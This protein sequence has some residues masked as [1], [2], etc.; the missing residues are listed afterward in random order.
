M[1]FDVRAFGETGRTRMKETSMDYEVPID[2]LRNACDPQEFGFAATDSVEPLV[3]IVGQERALRALRFGLSMENEGF[4]IYVA[5]WPGSGRTSA[6]MSFLGEVAKRKPTPPDWCYVNNFADPYYP[7]AI[8]LSPGQGRQF[9]HDVHT[10]ISEIRDRIP[11]AFESEQYT[12]KREAVLGALEQQRQAILAAAERVA[13]QKGFTIQTSPSGLALVPLKDGR[14]VTEEEF[15]ALGEEKRKEIASQRTLA[16]SEVGVAMKQARLPEKRAEERLQEM[17]RE[18]AL[19]AIRPLV[20]ELKDKYQ[21]SADVVSYLAAVQDSVQDNLS[22][23]QDQEQEEP[24]SPESEA[25]A[26]TFWR[27]YEVNVMVDHSEVQGAPVLIELN[28]TYYNLF[29]R[30]EREAEFGALVTDFTMLKAGA[31][32]RANGGYIVLPVEGLLTNAQA[33]D[34]LKRALRSQQ[35]SIE[36]VAEQTGTVAVKSVRPEPI[37]LQVKV[38]LIGDP[39]SYSFLYHS[40]PDL[41]ELFKVKAHFDVSMK[42]TPENVH[43]Y[44]AFFSTLCRKESLRPLRRDAAARLIEYGSWLAE[45]QEELS[46]HFARIADTVREANLYAGQDGAAH[47]TRQHIQKAIDERVHRSDMLQQHMREE[48]LKGAMLIDTDGAVVGQVNGLTVLSMGDY[49]FGYPTRITAAAGQGRDGVLDIDREA[50]LDGPVH[51]KGVLTLSGY[52]L[53]KYAQDKPLTL[54]AHLTFEQSYDEVEGDSASSSELYALLSALADLPIQQGI[55]VTGSV[56]QHGQ[57]QAIGA[58]NEKVEGFFDLC[59]ARGLTG[60]QGVVIPESNVRNLMLKEEVVTAARD[61]MFH[62]YA[63]QSVDQGLAILTGVEAGVRAAD[64]QYPSGTVHAKVDARLC[65][66]VRGIEEFGK[67]RKYEQGR[68]RRRSSP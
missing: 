64:G 56:N 61:G 35:I 34:G 23:F 21:A 68:K 49:E 48:M 42:R 26:A 62:V 50:D 30:I 10:L 25:S 66:L 31:L 2:K 18:V 43:A 7:K 11:L 46:T 20:N 5:G 36:D 41:E 52:L 33:W 6:V 9:S 67:D 54:S 65:A 28:V 55:A 58:V 39:T 8:R 17:D 44:V 24:A 60:R 45:D 27:Q 40:D 3:G 29:G 37:P 12:Q 4:N 47:I 22:A 14:A 32:H 53:Q 13:Q 51:T 19:S 15:V 38:I 63:V 57:V 1:I 16:E 59:K